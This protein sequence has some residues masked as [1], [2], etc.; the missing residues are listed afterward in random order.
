MALR[1]RRLL[2][3]A[4]L[5]AWGVGCGGSSDGTSDPTSA[6]G[7]APIV[8]LTAA[9]FESQVLGSSRAVMVEFYRTTCPACRSM[10]TIVENLA[11]DFAGRAVVGQVDV[12]IERE[13]LTRYAVD[14]VPTFVFFKNGREV[15]RHV[16]TTDQSTLADMLRA[17]LAAS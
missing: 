9:N 17:A 6:S 13:L 4:G 12:V 8:A 15:A 10:T 1:R 7:D 5:L 11:R 3:L 16:G 2:V 14:A